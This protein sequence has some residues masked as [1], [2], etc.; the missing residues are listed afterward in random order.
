[1]ETMDRYMFMG[2]KFANINFKGF[3]AAIMG[4]MGD[5]GVTVQELGNKD[6]DADGDKGKEK[7]EEK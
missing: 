1:M 2:Y 3:E 7:Q 6:K 5:F 4:K